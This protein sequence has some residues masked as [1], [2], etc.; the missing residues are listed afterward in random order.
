MTL[1]GYGHYGDKRAW[2]GIDPGITTG[3]AFV[4]D[5]DGEVIGSA[6]LK[7]DSLAE[8]LDETIRRFHRAGY[9]LTCVV[10][11]MPRYGKM[12]PLSAALESVRSVILEVV[13]GTYS[14]DVF[15]VTPGEWK[16]SRVARTTAL[17]RGHYSPHERDA[18]RM[19]LYVRAREASRGN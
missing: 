8:K 2:M 4:R 6:N 17:R 10:E 19:A 12:S 14:L 1:D 18:I 13:E 15:R 9:T 16:P 5:E 11:I 7:P 3:V